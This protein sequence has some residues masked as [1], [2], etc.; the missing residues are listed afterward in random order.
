MSQAK[1]IVICHIND[2]WHLVVVDDNGQAERPLQFDTIEQ[3]RAY[4]EL[5]FSGLQ[6]RRGPRTSRQYI[7]RRRHIP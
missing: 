7:A 5:H 6:V 3:A 1:R 2:K 4:A